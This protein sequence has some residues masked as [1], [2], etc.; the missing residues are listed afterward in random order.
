ML[1]VVSA[2]CKTLAS[3]ARTA[4]TAAVS[5]AANAQ[6]YLSVLDTCR[7]SKGASAFLPRCARHTPEGVV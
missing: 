3:L 5:L 2:A 4:P 6:N 1:Q 7:T